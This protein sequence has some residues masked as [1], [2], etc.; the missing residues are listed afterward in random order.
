MTLN[1][2]ENKPLDENDILRFAKPL[3]NFRGVFTR[4]NLPKKVTCK[5]FECGVINLDDENGMGTHWV[6]FF[7]N[8]KNAFYFDSFGNLPPQI[9][10]LNYIGDKCVIYYNHKSYQTYR[11]VNCGHLCIKFLYNMYLQSISKQ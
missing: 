5:D 7:R 11:E 1:H 3:P 6:C 4:E 2:I 10:F 8:K 9:E